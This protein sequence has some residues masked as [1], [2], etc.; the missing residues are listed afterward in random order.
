MNSSWRDESAWWQRGAIYQ[1]YPRSFKDSRGDGIGDLPGIASKLD[2][3]AWLGVGAVWISPFYPSPMV[4]FGYDVTGYLDVDPIFGTLDDFDELLTRAHGLG[5]KVILDFVPNHTSDQHPW[6]QES[7]SSHTNP[8]SDWYI[9]RDARRNGG[10]PNNWLSHFGGPAW[11]LDERISKYYMHSFLPEQPDLNWR[12]PDVRDAMLDVLRFWLDGGVDGFR[13]DAIQA[14]IKDAQFR[15]DPPNPNYRKGVD[16]PRDSLLHRYSQDQPEAHA[17]I[18]DFRRLLDTYDDRVSI[19]EVSYS[20]SLNDLVAYYGRD[21]GLNLPANFKLITLPWQ[22]TAIHEYVDRYERALPS[23][24][25]PNYVLGN[26][27]RARVA[28]RIGSGQARVAAMLLLTLRGTPFIYYVEEIGMRDVEL[29]VHQLQDPHGIRVP[30]QGRDQARSPMQWSAEPHAGFSE[31]EPWLPVGA[32]YRTINVSVQREDSSSMLNLY[33]RLLEY[34]RE[35][36]ALTIGSYRSLDGTPDDCFLYFREFEGQRL[37]IALNFSAKDRTV[38]LE[39]PA[40]G[41]VVL[42]TY[43]DREGHINLSSLRLRSHEGCLIEL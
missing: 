10:P 4:D 5:L 19:G 18:R 23:F 8:K 30:G 2:Y 37:L 12:N 32:S 31:S 39:H 7:R 24:A 38:S 34:R 40:K 21:D 27:D 28:S 11:T 41:R 15:D 35:T 43:L 3:L 1:I 17:R 26:H 13:M 14:L 16:Q 22:A 9:W 33:R 42:S 29:S 6:F 20:L 25:W 36:P